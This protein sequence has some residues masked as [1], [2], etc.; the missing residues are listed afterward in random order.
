MAEATCNKAFGSLCF[1]SRLSPSV[2][3]RIPN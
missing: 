2:Q 1:V 3:I